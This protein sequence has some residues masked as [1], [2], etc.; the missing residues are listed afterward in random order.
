MIWSWFVPIILINQKDVNSF[1]KYSKFGNLNIK[2]L[3]H[4]NFFLH[5]KYQFSYKSSIF[6]F[7]IVVQTHHPTKELFY[8]P[9]WNRQRIM[10]FPP[11]NLLLNVFLL[12]FFPRI[13]FS[14]LVML[15]WRQRPWKRFVLF[16]FAKKKRPIS[17]NMHFFLFYMTNVLSL[18]SSAI[19]ISLPDRK[20]WF[21]SHC[22]CGTEG[23]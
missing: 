16:S 9:V 7:H 15:W 2:I 12:Q 6:S 3:A 8:S 19:L 1:C 10:M 5:V 18:P 22:V 11:P 21:F 14:L 17:F 23:T 20:N 13:L 4:C